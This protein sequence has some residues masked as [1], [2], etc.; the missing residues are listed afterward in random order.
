[1]SFFSHLVSRVSD[2]SW[3]DEAPLTVES[4][5]DYLSGEFSEEELL[6]KAEVAFCSERCFA[7]CPLTSKDYC[8]G[9]QRFKQKL[10]SE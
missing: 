9:L 4:A 7:G 10:I 2:S 3:E 8:G 1:M 5:L 6:A